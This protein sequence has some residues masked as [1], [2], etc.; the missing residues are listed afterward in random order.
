M[1]ATYLHALATIRATGAATPETSYYTPL[2]NLFNAVGATLK[3]PVR[4]V[5]QLADLGAGRPDFGL[6]AA[7]QFERPAD[8]SSPERR[9]G[10]LP[11]RGAGEVKGPNE[12]LDR[13]LAGKQVSKYWDKYRQVLVTNLRQFAFVAE[14]AAGHPLLLDSFTLAPTEAEFWALCHAPT[15]PAATLAEGFTAFLARCLRHAAPLDEPKDLA[16][17]LAAFA[18]EARQRLETADPKHLQP[19]RTALEE[20]LGVRFDGDKGGRFLRATVVQTL[21]YGVFSAWVLWHRDG[22]GDDGH[23]NDKPG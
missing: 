19:L 10:A 21:F 8:G 18:R 16:W 4:A 6:F 22:G 2:E 9:A 13:L 14:D 15:P 3:P 5:F 11:E 20:T 7:G 12:S 17:F 1:L 23:P